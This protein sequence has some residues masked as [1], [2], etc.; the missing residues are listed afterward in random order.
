[1]K[2]RNTVCRLIIV[3]LFSLVGC[4]VDH[5]NLKRIDGEGSSTSGGDKLRLLFFDAKNWAASRAF[6]LD[7]E[8]IKN[9]KLNKAA[10]KWVEKNSIK[11]NDYKVY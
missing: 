6:S 11:T 2:Y 4:G 1:M 8:N 10:S 3:V 7:R 5:L 9:L